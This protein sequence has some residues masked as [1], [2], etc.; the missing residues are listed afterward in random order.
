MLVTRFEDLEVWQIAR[1]I[2][3]SIYQ[4]TYNQQFSK[5]FAL[6]DQVRRSAISIMAN[7]A[8]GFGS[9][10]KNEFIRF[11]RYS[12]SSAAETKSHLY[13]AIDLDYITQDQFNECAGNIE[14]VT[15]KIKAFI[16]HINKT[17]E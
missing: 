16:K 6:K 12:I 2:A 3:N 14:T 15:K 8:E 11:L 1:N 4:L 5:D 7:I 17:K 9:K 13:L 10:S